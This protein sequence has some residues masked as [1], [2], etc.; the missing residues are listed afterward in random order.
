M[1]DFP[2]AGDTENFHTK[3]KK[4]QQYLSGKSQFEKFIP[5]YFRGREEDR[6]E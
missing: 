1:G 2:M 4:F 6:F 3:T 5:L